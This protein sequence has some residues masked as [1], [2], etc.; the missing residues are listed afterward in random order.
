MGISALCATQSSITELDVSSC[1][2]VTDMTL[3]NIC[4]ELPNL[5]KLSLKSCRAVTDAGI[6]LLTKLSHLQ[7]INLQGLQMITSLGKLY[8]EN[9][10]A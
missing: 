3:K 9:E 6:S 10:I 5:Q 2:R 1:A 4:S 7:E 8:F